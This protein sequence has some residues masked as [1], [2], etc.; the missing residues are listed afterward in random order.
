MKRGILYVVWGNYN[1]AELQRSIDSVTS[2]GYDYHVAEIKDEGIGLAHK[3]KMYD[4][5]PKEWDT[6]LFLDT[7]CTVKGN[8]D[9]GFEMAE[10]HGIAC[11]IAPASSAYL[12]G[13]EI[14]MKLPEGLP[15]YNTGVIFFSRNRG[16]IEFPG[17]IGFEIRNWYGEFY[18]WGVPVI[19]YFWKKLCNEFPLSSSNDQPTFSKAINMEDSPFIL[20]RTWNYRAKVR[21]EAKVTHGEIKILHA[22]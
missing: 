12:A 1:K 13:K 20:P 5:A 11:C 4:L 16:L 18:G 6:V 3:A 19:F 17:S 22:R 7:D 8:L 14:G 10:R 9:Y 2:H 15:Q 21:Y